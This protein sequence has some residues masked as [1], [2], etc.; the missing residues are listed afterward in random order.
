M[1]Q[2]SLTIRNYEKGDDATQANIFNTVIVDMIPDPVLINAEKV[3]KRHEEAGFNPEQVK[4]LVNSENKIV[5]YTECRIHGGFHGIFYPMIL[6]EYRSQEALD[7]LFKAIY[8][9][10]KEDCRKN[11]GTIESHY[12]YDFKKAHEYFKS[13]TIAK[14][15]AFHDSREMR[16]LVKK[17]DSKNPPD[18]SVIPLTEN[19]LIS[20]VDYRK[21]KETI[22]GE[23]LTLEV[24][25][26]RFKNNEMSSENCFLIY[27]KDDLVGYVRHGKYSPSDRGQE[28][29]TVYGNFEAMIL[30]REFHDG[31]NLRKTMLQSGKEYYEKH[32]AF[33]L[34]AS[35]LLNNPA[36]EF[37]KKLGFILN[38][39]QGSIHYIYEQ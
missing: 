28:D 27:Y 29:T 35:I 36:L 32:Q 11:P 12:A 30:D 24:Y 33:E 15:V 2:E 3:Q 17:I 23:D 22:V 21:S 38:E 37:Y 5:G 16:L 20:L 14:I 1:T 8:E 10:A 39:N 34:V 6:E 25:Q 4:Y 19:D 26:E 13:Q 7:Q 31:F 9:Y 18:F